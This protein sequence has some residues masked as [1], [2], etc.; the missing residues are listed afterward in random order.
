MSR[1]RCFRRR[2]SP[3]SL[4]LALGPWSLHPFP[5]RLSTR[6]LGGFGSTLTPCAFPACLETYGRRPMLVILTFLF[7]VMLWPSVPGS[8]DSL[9]VSRHVCA[10][11]PSFSFPRPL[12][13]TSFQSS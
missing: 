8:S 6:E 12:R 1:L 2:L 5:V 10:A 4:C 3:T 13:P 11:S 7:V 9:S